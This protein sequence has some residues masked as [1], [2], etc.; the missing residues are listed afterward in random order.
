MRLALLAAALLS[1][2]AIAVAQPNRVAMEPANQWHQKGREIYARAISIPT[3]QGRGQMRQLADY[4]DQQFRGAGFTD[5]TIHDHEVVR[6][7]D[8]TAALIL[9]W[10][11][12]RPSGRKA[13]LLMAHMDVVDARREDWSRE[14]Y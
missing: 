5:I 11:A 12:A 7:N 8:R 1:T 9:R 3:A 13:I 10:P 14:P 4:L 2:T 6:P